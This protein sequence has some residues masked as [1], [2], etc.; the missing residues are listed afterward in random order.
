[1]V[2]RVAGVGDLAAVLALDRGAA[3]APHWPEAEYRAALEDGGAVSTVPDGGGSRRACWWG[4]RWGRL[5]LLETR[6]WLSWRAWRV[7]AEARRQGIGRMLCE[8]VAAW[9]RE[10]GAETLQLEVRAS[11]VGA[12][13]LY[14]GMGFGVMGRRRDY[15]R[16]PMDD[17][18]LMRLEL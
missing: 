3:E 2:V 8:A 11:S 5:L 13:L 7:A 10:E 1:M 9:C 4:L 16:E 17:A 14:E 12:N 18:L 6:F 15:Y